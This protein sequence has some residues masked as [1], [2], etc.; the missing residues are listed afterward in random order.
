MTKRSPHK[1]DKPFNDTNLLDAYGEWNK[2][3]RVTAFILRAK[4]NFLNFS[5][6]RQVGPLT[7]QELEAATV[8]L[9][10]MDQRE[11]LTEEIHT[12]KPRRGSNQNLSFSWDSELEILRI[13]GRITS[14][15]LSRDEQQ[16]IFIS[17]DGKLANL[18]IRHAHKI[19]LHG[20]SQI[21][22]QFL[23]KRFWIPNARRLTK[24]AIN[25]CPICFKLKMK[26]SEQMMASLRKGVRRYWSGLL[27]TL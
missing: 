12:L 22:L 9:I 14:P 10:K 19:I 15:N 11:S 6:E 16:P 7:P 18:L 21:M 3:L 5:S 25:K 27:R 17:K 2:L 13:C 24:M 26:T 8:L 23:R 20:G 1:R 4:T